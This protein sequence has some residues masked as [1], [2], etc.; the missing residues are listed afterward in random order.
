MKSDK[1]IIFYNPPQFSKTFQETVP[2][3]ET[4]PS[5]EGNLGIFVSL[6]YWDA[7]FTRKS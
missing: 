7:I 4:R 6:L 5:L 1:P 3:G 2:M